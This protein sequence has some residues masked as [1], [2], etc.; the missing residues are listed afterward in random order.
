MAELLTPG[1]Q[2]DEQPGAEHAIARSTTAITA[3]VGR[4]LRGRCNQP[5]SIASFA[6]FQRHF[7]GLWQ[8]SM[9]GYSIEQFFDNG[10]RHAIV[11]RVSN[12]A[13]PQTLTLPSQLAVI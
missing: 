1:I 2:V 7:G 4:A 5:V 8:P 6:D 3:F 9:L 13:R 11:V 10:G 12:S